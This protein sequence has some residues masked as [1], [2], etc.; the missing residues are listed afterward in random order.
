[1]VLIM[2]VVFTKYAEAIAI[3]DKQAETVAMEIL[4]HWICRFR[5]PVQIHSDNGTEFVN[6]LNKELFKLLD[7][8]H[9]TTTPGHPQCNMQ[10]EVFN[11]TMTK[12]LASFVDGS[13]LDWEHYLLALQFSYNTN[14]HSI[15]S[16]TPF[17]LLYGMKPRTPSIPGQNVQRKFYGET[18]AA[19]LLQ[20]LQKARQIAKENMEE[21]QKEYKIQHHNKAVIGIELKL[22]KIP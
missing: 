15:I 14:Y 11:K 13:I 19:D 7:I 16:T 12:Y 18:F 17:E 5:S 4:I 6:K 22:L 20:I 21:K 9:T 2:T 1:M 10:A 8:K 3:P